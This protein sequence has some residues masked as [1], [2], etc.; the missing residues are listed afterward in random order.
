M[1]SSNFCLLCVN[2]VIFNLWR[3]YKI[4]TCH[5]SGSNQESHK[6]S[7]AEIPL[8][9]KLQH[10]FITVKWIYWKCNLSIRILIYFSVLF[11]RYWT[12]P[13]IYFLVHVLL[14]KTIYTQ[15]ILHKIILSYKIRRGEES[16]K[17]Y[18]SYTKNRLFI[19]EPALKG[20]PIS[21]VL[22]KEINSLS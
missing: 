19:G 20:I 12:F 8:M 11:I 22:I 13:H 21:P 14:F 2:V 16:T 9:E 4:Q 3:S 7:S 5:L 18:W 6:V 17:G 15:T 10:I 1:F